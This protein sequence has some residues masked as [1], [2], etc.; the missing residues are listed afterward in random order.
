MVCPFGVPAIGV[1]YG[2]R[3]LWVVCPVGIIGPMWPLGDPMQRL[4]MR[5][6]GSPWAW[7]LPVSLCA[8]FAVPRI[9]WV[10]RVGTHR[11]DAQGPNVWTQQG[12]W[13]TQGPWVSPGAPGCPHAKKNRTVKYQRLQK[14]LL[15]GHPNP[16]I[17]IVH[18]QQRRHQDHRDW[19]QT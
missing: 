12:P 18:Q 5:L 7:A 3:V 2:W 8:L 6:R 19:I 17:S 11:L 9:P 16:R 10:L 15:K 1:S 13:P 4:I 14:T